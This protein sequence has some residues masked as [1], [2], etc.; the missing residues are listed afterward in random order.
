MVVGKIDPGSVSQMKTDSKFLAAAEKTT[1]SKSNL[2][3]RLKRASEI[4]K[5]IE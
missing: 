3:T 4:I 5:I 1:T 2:L